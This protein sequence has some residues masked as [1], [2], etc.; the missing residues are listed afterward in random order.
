MK[1]LAAL[2]LSWGK[3]LTSS[4]NLQANAAHAT[5]PG[6]RRAL[7]KDAAPAA[8]RSEGGGGVNARVVGRNG[9]QHYGRGILGCADGTTPGPH[10][11]SFARPPPRAYEPNSNFG[12]LKCRNR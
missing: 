11:I 9:K 10:G 8:A 12:G 2:R 5:H 6:F 1:P 4:G 3:A 7:E